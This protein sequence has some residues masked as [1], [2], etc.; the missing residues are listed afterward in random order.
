MKD[1]HHVG[2][3]H[4]NIC[5]C[6]GPPGSTSQ[7]QPKEHIPLNHPLQDQCGNTKPTTSK[8]QIDRM[9]NNA[10]VVEKRLGSSLPTI[11][12]CCINSSHIY[13]VIVWKH[14]K[15]IM[16]CYGSQR[17][18]PSEKL[19]ICLPRC[20]RRSLLSILKVHNWPEISV[21]NPRPATAFIPK[22]NA[23]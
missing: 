5:R 17:H 21:G 7:R 18:S 1:Q 4:C 20:V 16:Q 6:W 2:V 22:A 14:S 19:L 9:L 11:N 10:K 3:N 15:S 23:Q 12:P 13:T 8:L